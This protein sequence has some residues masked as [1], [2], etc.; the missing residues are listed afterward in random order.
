MA[1]SLNQKSFRSPCRQEPLSLSKTRRF[2]KPI[3]Q[4]AS[5]W[6]KYE[7]KEPFKVDSLAD[8]SDLFGSVAGN[9]GGSV[10]AG[11]GGSVFLFVKVEGGMGGFP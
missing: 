7:D 4:T 9:K 2:A 3:F 11:G 6:K 1:E 10:R 8:I 5:P